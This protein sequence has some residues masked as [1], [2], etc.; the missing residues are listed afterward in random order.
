[1]T[2]FIEIPP[3]E[4]DEDLRPAPLLLF[5][6]FL[7]P[8][9]F[10]TAA[11]LH[12]Q[13]QYDDL[14]VAIR[15]KLRHSAATVEIWEIHETGIWAI[16][17][18]LPL[19]FASGTPLVF[20]L[21]PPP[22]WDFAPIPNSF[23]QWQILRGRSFS[24]PA[25]FRAAADARVIRV[26]YGL[27]RKRV[28][29]T[30]HADANDLIEF[31]VT[32]VFTVKK[33]GLIFRLYAENDF[34]PVGYHVSLTPRR[35]RLLEFRG[36]TAPMIAVAD[37]VVFTVYSTDI[38]GDGK[39][40]D[41]LF[42]QNATAKDLIRHIESLGLMELD[43]G[44]RVLYAHEDVMMGMMKSSDQLADKGNPFRVEPIPEAQMDIPP[45]ELIAVTWN[46]KQA[47]KLEFL[48]N[49]D[50][51]EEFADL[52]A[53]IRE[54]IEKIRNPA[55]ERELGSCR[56]EFVYFDDR[57][58]TLYDDFQLRDLG[59]EKGYVS[60]VAKFGMLPWIVNDVGTGIPRSTGIKFKN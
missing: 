20:S 22:K 32:S 10:C 24:C 18:D 42:P 14:A 19:K 52:K 12:S 7:P 11:I 16:D 17:D 59:P 56:F 43:D 55:L 9:H 6:V 48:V 4:D 29:V 2:D 36:I 25:Y 23:L 30:D 44:F 45:E 1:M 31:L 34:R 54:R 49:F 37:R 28:K 33:Q 21:I 38:G 41:A 50:P 27:E 13:A 46:R 40:F 35:F 15:S 53:K 39:R 60:I 58:I 47:Q 8:V 57:P 51:D 5:Y 3:Y 26:V